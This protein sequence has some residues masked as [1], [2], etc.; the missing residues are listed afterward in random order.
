MGVLEDTE[1]WEARTSEAAF[2]AASNAEQSYMQKSMFNSVD[3]WRN[4]MVLFNS[5]ML[6]RWITVRSLRVN[7]EMR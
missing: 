2:Q 7:I 5:S 3:F 1:L 4:L 6:L